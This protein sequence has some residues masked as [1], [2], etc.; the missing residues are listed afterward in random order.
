MTART[1][2]NPF[3]KMSLELGPLI[4]FFVANARWGIFAAT[5]VFMVA[6]VAALAASY[7]LTRRVPVMAVV[8]AFVVLVFGGLTL[9]LQNDVFIK[10]KP[11]I[12][13]LLFCAVLLAG[14]AAGKP[15]LA[16]VFDSV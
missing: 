6:V 7:T 9:L 14:L 2:I 5:G 3:L 13:Y 1:P 4:L 10:L 15:L 16:L 11:T 12:I 8:S